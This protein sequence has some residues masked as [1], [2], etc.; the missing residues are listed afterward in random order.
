MV[1]PCLL[2]TQHLTSLMIRCVQC[3]LS[4]SVHCRCHLCKRS[5]RASRRSIPPYT[6]VLS[7][8]RSESG[9]MPEKTADIFIALAVILGYHKGALYNSRDDT[10]HANN[11]LVFCFKPLG[12]REFFR[13]AYPHLKPALTLELRALQNRLE[14]PGTSHFSWIGNCAHRT[15]LS[16][17]Y[18]RSYS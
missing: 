9:G 10:T 11:L 12:L 18:V 1:S 13:A 4:H 8:A 2:L 3:P 14:L 6:L 16:L 5:P 17:Y 15:L 7:S